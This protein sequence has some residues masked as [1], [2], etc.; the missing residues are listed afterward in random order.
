[1]LCAAAFTGTLSGCGA[2][3][4]AGKTVVRMLQ[5]KPE[6]VAAFEEMERRFNAGHDDIELRIESPNEAMV[7]LKTRLVKE[8]YPD[9]VG[10]GGDVNYSNFLDADLFMDLSDFEGI[11]DIKDAY[12]DMEEELEFIPRQGVYALPYAANCA[13][14]LYNRAMFREHGWTVPETWSEFTALCE[15]IRQSGITPVYLGYKDTWTCLSPWNSLAVSL[16]PADTCAQVN[17]GE[18]TFAQQYGPAAEKLRE[19]LQY[20]ESDPYA[21]SYNDACTA[22]ARGEAAMY[23]IGSYAVPQI[24]SVN[25]DMD[26]DSFPLPAGE[27]PEENILTSGVDLHFCVMKSCKNKEAAYEVLRFLLEDETVQ[28][29]LDDQNAVPCKKGDFT[30]P[31]MLDGMRECLNAGRV[32]DFHDHHYPS[33]MSVDAMLQTYLMDE[34]PDALENF[35]AR[36]DT[37]WVRYNRDLIEKTKAYEEGR[38]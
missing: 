30:L 2:A 36:F 7:V 12:M 8:D 3:D 4:G 32:G 21:Y 25:P 18:T 9:I 26:I 6:A 37:E 10:I 11:G 33:E 17:R 35:L 16:S 20:A 27:T 31:P 5:Y 13:G 14:V 28:L 22:F 24:R 19:L 15:T 1:M 34:S 38:T 23:P 29:Y